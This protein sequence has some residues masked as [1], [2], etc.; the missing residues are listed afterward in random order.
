[1][2]AEARAPGPTL[3]RARP[4]SRAGRRQPR[5]VPPPPPAQGLEFADRVVTSLAD[6][7]LFRNA[8]A[9]WLSAQLYG[10]AS[11]QPADE[12]SP[13]FWLRALGLLTPGAALWAVCAGL[14][15][16]SAPS[17]LAKA[18]TAQRFVRSAALEVGARGG[19]RSVGRSVGRAGGRAAGEG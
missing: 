15:A 14:L 3:P 7:F 6:E 4:L 16:L 1:M 13:L 18:R 2:R 10:L 9:G 17:Y 12:D 19:G 5:R 8:L 11:A